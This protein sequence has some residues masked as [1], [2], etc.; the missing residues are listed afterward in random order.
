MR[1][2]ET[3]LV[4]AILVGLVQPGPVGLSCPGGVEL[5]VVLF[6]FGGRP[7][8][9]ARQFVPALRYSL[10]SGHGDKGTGGWC[11][12]QVIGLRSVDRWPLATIIINCVMLVKR[13]PTTHTHPVQSKS[14]C[15]KSTKIR[16]HTHHTQTCN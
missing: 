6:L 10:G 8:S 3:L 7:L 13:T 11:S 9:R 16:T 2:I 12:G 5:G 14:I 4:R 15:C 1:L